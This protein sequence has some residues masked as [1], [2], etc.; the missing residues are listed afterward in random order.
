MEINSVR[1]VQD[2]V[3]GIHN[4]TTEFR[5]RKEGLVTTYPSSNV[6]LTSQ[7]DVTATY[8]KLL[9]EIDNPRLSFL[10]VTLKAE[11]YDEDKVYH[12]EEE[13]FMLGEE[14]RKKVE[15]ALEDIKFPYTSYYLESDFGEVVAMFFRNKEE[16]DYVTASVLSGC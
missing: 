12:G 14:D 4:P 6:K 15:K 11:G 13:E 2:D 10:E 7:V 3:A 16:N 5:V 1:W 9:K 8:K